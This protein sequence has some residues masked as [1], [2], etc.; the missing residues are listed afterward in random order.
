V[1]IDGPVR[2][3]ADIAVY[4][5]AK[6]RLA[7]SPGTWTPRGVPRV[8]DERVTVDAPS[9]DVDMKT[10]DLTAKGGVTTR[11]QQT[12][13]SRTTA[14]F[15]GDEPVIG[16][17]VDLSYQSAGG[18]AAY[19]GKPG[20]PARLVQGS[21]VIEGATI[22]L[23]DEKGSLEASGGVRT[24]FLMTKEDKKAK[25][26][27]Y[28][29]TAQTFSY[30]DAKRVGVYRAGKEGALARMTGTDESEI[31]GRTITMFLAAASRTLD[32]FRVEREAWARLP[33]DYE[34]AGETLTFTSATDTYV[35]T[36]SPARVKSPNSDGKGCLLSTGETIEFNRTAGR[37]RQ[38]QGQAF[39]NSKQIACTETIR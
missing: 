37:P 3:D 21:T 39:Q 29:T 30:D 26:V 15:E 22:T 4:E 9:I 38:P 33:G 5:A 16:S 19:T 18:A 35:L 2:A 36:G 12:K 17:S 28:R 10:H 7:L 11:S 34:A 23:V 32:G 8:R 25:P 27:E 31:E 20:A 13:S 14:L 24:V 6:E 1:F